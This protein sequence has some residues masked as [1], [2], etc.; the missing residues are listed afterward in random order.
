[1]VEE[2]RE[3]L[4][5]HKVSLQG[6]DLLAISLILN[7]FKFYYNVICWVLGGGLGRFGRIWEVNSL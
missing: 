2:V 1:M 4:D 3:L 6:N 7:L 5:L